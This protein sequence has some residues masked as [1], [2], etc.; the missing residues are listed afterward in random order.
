MQL[1]TLLKSSVLAL[2][3]LYLTGA[4]AGD[5]IAQSLQI[6]THFF[7]I[8]GRPTW[9]LEL[10]D[11]ESGQVFP[12]I[13]DVKDN[14]NFWIAFTKEHSYQV[15]ASE[16]SFD[17]CK[18][19]NFCHLENGILKGK[20]MFIRITGTLSPNRYASSCHVQK[21]SGT[22]FVIVKRP[23]IILTAAPPGTPVSPGTPTTPPPIQGSLQSIAQNPLVKSIV[24]GPTGAPPAAAPSA[25]AGPVSAK[26]IAGI[27][28]GK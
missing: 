22:Q 25:P 11:V 13:F 23:D 10:R 5:T 20:S 24:G 15:V 18:I 8:V 28:A 7:R 27:T 16:V 26:G 3:S 2:S 21:F 14:D 1:K 17:D 19:H 12:Y 6:Y 9:L 4:L